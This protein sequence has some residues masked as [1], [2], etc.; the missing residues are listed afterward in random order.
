LRPL[1]DIGE[2]GDGHSLVE[3]D[4]E[5]P[6][7]AGESAAMADNSLAAARSSKNP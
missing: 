2:N 7:D 3:I 6:A 5:L 1:I 4:I